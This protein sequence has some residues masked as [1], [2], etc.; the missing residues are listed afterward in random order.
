VLRKGIRQRLLERLDG[1]HRQGRIDLADGPAQPGCDRSRIA[2]RRADSRSDR[3]LTRRA[4][5][6]Y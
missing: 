4:A 3:R 2:A 6:C 1:E 5:W